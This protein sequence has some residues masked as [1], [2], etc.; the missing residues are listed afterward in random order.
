MTTVWKQRKL[1]LRHTEKFWGVSEVDDEGQE[2]ISTT[3]VLWN[4]GDEVCDRIVARGYE[5]DKELSK[6]SPTVAKSTVRILLAA[7]KDWKIQ[8]MDIKSAFLQGK[9]ISRDVYI[10]PPKESDTPK[11]K[12]WKL[13]KTLYGLIDAARQFYDNIEQ[14]LL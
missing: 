10:S 8:T 1:N 4:K 14:V 11:R 3:W 13:K 6:D 5:E 2:H 9:D 12:I 7:P